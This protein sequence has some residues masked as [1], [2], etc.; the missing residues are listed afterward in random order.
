MDGLHTSLPSD[1][2][3]ADGGIFPET[4][5]IHSQSEISRLHNPF[6]TMR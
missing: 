4:I 5:D 3:Q 2:V 6:P 1:A